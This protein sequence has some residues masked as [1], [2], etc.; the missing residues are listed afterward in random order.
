MG[1]TSVRITDDTYRMIIKTRGMFEQLFKTK[2]S[3]DD[4]VYLST[5][6]ISFIYET[7][8][9]LDAQNL[10]NIKEME[11]GSIKLEGI[12]NV[13]GALPGVVE[14]V[15]EIKDKLAE[16]EKTSQLAMR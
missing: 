15:T 11:D 1:G 16:K 9:R 3:L 6:L 5:R 2:L 12:E 13:Q 14:E 7:V 10:I 8:Q 4:T